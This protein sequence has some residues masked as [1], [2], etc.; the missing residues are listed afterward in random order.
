M[1]AE[2]GEKA[3]PLCGGTD[4]LIQLRAGTRQ[5]DYIVDVKRIP[6]LTGIAFDAKSGLRLGAAVS[7]IEI[8]ESQAMRQHY[9]GLTEAAH[10]IGSLQI[11][12]RASVGGNLGNGAPAAETTPALI[13]LGA[14]ARVVGP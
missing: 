3:R 9:P 12:S 1:L 6:E 7:C 11:Q 8:F 5:P 2:H 14:K 4:I 13:A 10:L